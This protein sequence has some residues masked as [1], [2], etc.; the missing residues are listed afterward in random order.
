MLSKKCIFLVY[1]V[2]FRRSKLPIVFAVL[3]HFLINVFISSMCAETKLALTKWTY[4]RTHCIMCACNFFQARLIKDITL[5][6]SRWIK[7]TYSSSMRFREGPGGSQYTRWI[8]W[9]WQVGQ[10]RNWLY[11]FR[12]NWILFIVKSNEIFKFLQNFTRFAENRPF[13]RKKL[14]HNILENVWENEA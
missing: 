13:A 11:N 7:W 2:T 9:G 3:L 1:A 4:L 6:F 14:P 10:K 5:I 12:E 8:Q